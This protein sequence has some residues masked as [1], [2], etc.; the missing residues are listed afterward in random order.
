MMETRF[1]NR[2]KLAEV[3]DLLG[4][5]VLLDGRGSLRG[6]FVIVQVITDKK[7]LNE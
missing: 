7:S 2:E 5:N 4:R 1:H 6:N 3:G